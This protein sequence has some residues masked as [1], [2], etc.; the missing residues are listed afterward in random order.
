MFM[1]ISYI[2]HFISYL[3]NINLRIPNTNF[4]KG[5]ALE[6]GLRFLQ[7]SN[8]FVELY[9]FLMFAKPLYQNV[10]IDHLKI[11]IFV[12]KKQHDKSLKN[13]SQILVFPVSSYFVLLCLF[14]L[15]I[16]ETV[17]GTSPIPPHAPL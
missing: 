8:L 10:C 11:F 3:L 4:S 5:S 2:C 17:S 12:K 9:G 1:I 7:D 13:A 16:R 15:F 6:P 14:L